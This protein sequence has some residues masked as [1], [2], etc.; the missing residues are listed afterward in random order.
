MSE[1]HQSN[2][3]NKKHSQSR[4]DISRQSHKN[5]REPSRHRSRD[6]TVSALRRKLAHGCH[7]LYL[8]GKAITALWRGSHWSADLLQRGNPLSLYADGRMYPLSLL[9]MEE[10]STRARAR[11]GASGRGRVNASRRRSRYGAEDDWTSL[12]VDGGWSWHSLVADGGWDLVLRK[13]TKI[14]LSSSS[15]RSAD[16]LERTSSRM[17]PLLRRCKRSTCGEGGLDGRSDCGEN[18]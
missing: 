7:D 3:K 2:N 1:H 16:V 4:T 9:A 8:A 14:P 15:H 12:D 17:Y 5:D 6:H 18:F 11:V 10:R 13:E